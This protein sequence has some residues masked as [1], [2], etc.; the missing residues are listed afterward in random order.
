MKK[1]LLMS[2]FI[3]CAQS[4]ALA[5]NNPAFSND[6]TVY[7]G[8][9]SVHY[10]LPG[11]SITVNLTIA[12]WGSTTSGSATI[13]YYL[14]KNA[15]RG[16]SDDV[17]FSQTTTVSAIGP[18]GFQSTSQA[19]TVPSVPVTGAYNL[20]VVVDI[21]NQVSE[22]N[23]NNNWN[24]LSFDIGRPNFD[25]SSV[26]SD[27]SALLGGTINING[28]L[29]NNGL[30]G[31]QENTKLK[32]VLSDDL[33][34]GDS[35]DIPIIEYTVGWMGNIGQSYSFNYDW[36]IHPDVEEGSY[37]IIVIA[38]FDEDVIESTELDNKYVLGSVD[39]ISFVDI[40]PL[41]ATTD[42]S[43]Y[44][45]GDLITVSFLLWN[46]GNET[47]PS[48]SSY[49]VKL[50]LREWAQLD[51]QF[52]NNNVVIPFDLFGGASYTQSV[53]T[54]LPS[55]LV[56]SDTNFEVIIEINEFNISNSIVENNYTNNDT[57]TPTFIIQ[58]DGSGS[59]SGGGPGGGG[60]GGG[61]VYARAKDLTG[62][63]T[64]SEE[65]IESPVLYPNPAVD[66]INISLS[67]S[68]DFELTIRDLS[69]NIKTT[70]S[71]KNTDSASIDIST[72]SSGF[73]LMRVKAEGFS[74]TRKFLKK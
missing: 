22:S 60:P 15:I 69:G 71:F 68:S 30:S 21:N 29:I 42:E 34:V 19:I 27:P 47:I 24:R 46:A 18:S 1:I 2:A 57:S 50:K 12:N 35:D 53:T 36:P 45:E 48:G 23:E 73:Y 10:A 16:D 65:N 49:R 32:I 52:Y 40:L 39:F 17:W 25:F 64:V 59:S 44:V 8:S 56:S 72:F 58:N 74:F 55:E 63:I 5:I 3:L 14:S 20:Y 7:D 6:L 66:A 9:T 61:G 37:N 13:G 43:S 54:Y 41:Q 70:Q 51:V 4:I 28:E 62:S 31:V 33:Y 67:N 26:S 11:E 38:D